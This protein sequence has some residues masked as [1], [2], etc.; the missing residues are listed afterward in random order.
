MRA[1]VLEAPKRLLEL[2]EWPDPEPGANEVAIDVLS[3]GVCRTDLQIADGDLKARTLPIVLGHQVVGMTNGKRV[4]V[5]WLASTDGV[6]RFCTSEREN[7]CER[8]TFTGWDRNGGYATRIIAKKDFVYSIP[9]DV[10]HETLAPLMCGG[11]IGYRSLRVSNI[12]P[13]QR[14][15]LF[16][17]GAS[18]L[19]AIQ[20]A[21]HWGCEVFVCTRSDREKA[22]AK[23]LGAVWVGGYEEKPPALLDSA[24]TFAPSGDVVI[25]A[26]RAIDRG[27]TV[28]INAI[29]LDRIPQFSYDDL[30]LER[31]LA[32]VAN[33]T[34]ND[35]REHCV[36]KNP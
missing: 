27:G 24:I 21:V 31:R 13:G 19:L 36:S 20:V 29:H 28:A 5:A 3:C 15:G 6:C 2:R 30:W 12:K 26:L 32:S 1:M 4:G 18:A 10:P 8:A 23:A 34:R 25:A 35:A 22:R 33:F 16:G 14:L 9:E 7:L 17:F 11:I